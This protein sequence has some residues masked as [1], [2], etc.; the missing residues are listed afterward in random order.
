V[1]AGDAARKH[2]AAIAACSV[3]VGDIVD[4]THYGVR[5]VVKV[6]VK[7]VLV[8]GSFGNVKV[9]K[10]FIRPAPRKDI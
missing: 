6:N 1:V 4:T 8:E 5:R 3:N 2:E 9:C 7:T 10:S